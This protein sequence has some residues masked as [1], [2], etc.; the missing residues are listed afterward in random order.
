M[1]YKVKYE[2][3]EGSDSHEIEDDALPQQSLLSSKSKQQRQQQPRLSTRSWI[4]SLIIISAIVGLV[5]GTLCFHWGKREGRQAERHD[6]EADW[7]CMFK[8]QSNPFCR[9]NE[10]L[11]S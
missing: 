10:Y 5:S 6:V 8:S 2:R 7:F 3:V 11:G 1:S 4:T 9:D